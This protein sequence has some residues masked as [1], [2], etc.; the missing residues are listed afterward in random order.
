MNGQLDKMSDKLELKRKDE[1]VMH[2]AQQS[3]SSSINV[4]NMMP[5][6]AN[7]SLLDLHAILKSPMPHIHLAMA[8]KPPQLI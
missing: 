3:C 5:F 8:T 1:T 7:T 6:R 4:P 2:R